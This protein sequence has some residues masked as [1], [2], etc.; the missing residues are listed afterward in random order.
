MSRQHVSFFGPDGSAL[1]C[2]KG[3]KI[4]PAKTFGFLFLIL[5]RGKTEKEEANISSIV[6]NCSSAI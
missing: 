1:L 5:L 3:F 6:D 2:M 4:D